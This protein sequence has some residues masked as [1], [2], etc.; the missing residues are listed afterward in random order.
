LWVDAAS[1]AFSAWCLSRIGHV[2]RVIPADVSQCDA[3]TNLWT[4]LREGIS[5]VRLHVWLWGTFTAASFTYLLFLGPTE[6]L[7]P[8]LV[9]NELHGSAASLG[10]VLGTGGVGALAAAVLASQRDQV[11][12]PVTF[13][14]F[15][16]A[17]ATPSRGWLWTGYPSMGVGR[18]RVCDQR[19]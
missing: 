3:A 16:W 6:V 7:L 18:N 10:L 19:P 9:K 1:F 11:R 15:A 4:D 8:F 13:M 17:A 2:G 12:R 5:Y 14:Y